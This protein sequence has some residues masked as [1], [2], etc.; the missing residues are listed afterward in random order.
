M[1]DKPLQGRVAVIT[2]GA[3]GIGMAIAERFATDGAQ[4]VIGDIQAEAGSAVAQRLGGLFVE[5]DLSRRADCQ[6]LIARAV[7][8]YGTV[9]I[10]VNNA[11][12]Q[13][14][15]S[16]EAFPEDTWDK[17][18]AL[19][20]TAPFLLTKYV[21]PTMKAQGWGRIINIASIHGQVASPLKSAY[22]AAKH[23]LIGLTRTTALEG[24]TH[25]ITVNAICPAYVRTPLVEKQIAD[26]AH[27]RNL[28]PEEVIEKVMLEP[29]AIK[30]LIEPEEVA[31][32]AAYLCSE[33]ASVTTGAVLAIALGWTA[34]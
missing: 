3:S 25:G 2:G 7:E 10:L 26:Q 1:P 16:I 5:A 30:R 6:T 24:G 13:H 18:L 33:A 20:L 32:L 22:V 9:D 28:P 27:T 15:D 11:G 17:M 23:G 21:W 29:A 31:A 12:F 19:M 34:R 4:V 8:T 14:I